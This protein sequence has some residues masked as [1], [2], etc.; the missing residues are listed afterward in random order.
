[1]QAGWNELA[2]TISGSGGLTFG[3][4]LQG[5]CDS[6]IFI[7][8]DNHL[9]LTG[10][11]TINMGIVNINSDNALG[12]NNNPIVLNG[13]IGN[14]SNTVGG[15]LEAYNGSPTLSNPVVIGPNGGTLT[16]EGGQGFQLSGPVSG[17]G[18]LAVTGQGTVILTN[19]NNNW[20]GGT[21]INGAVLQVNSGSNLG[22]GPVLITGSGVLNLQGTTNTNSTNDIN[23]YNT[24]SYGDNGYSS[25]YGYNNNELAVEAASATIGALAGTGNV[26]LTFNYDYSASWSDTPG[27]LTFGNA[28]S[29]SFYGMIE[30]YLWNNCASDNMGGN[31]IYAGTGTFTFWGQ[32]MRPTTGGNINGYSA[33]TTIESGTFTVNG[34]LAG[35]GVT[36]SGGML[37]GSGSVNTAVTVNSGGTLAGT[38]AINGNVSLVGGTLS[39]GVTYGSAV[40]AVSGASTISGGTFN[41]TLTVNSGATLSVNATIAPAAVTV[42]AGGVLQGTGTVNQAITLSGTL[43]GTLTINGNVTSAGGTLSGG[44]TYGSAVTAVSGASTISGGTF[45][46]SLTVNSGATLSVN[47]TIAPTAVTVNAGGVLQGNASITAPSFT[48]CS[49]GTLTGALGLTG[50]VVSNGGAITPGGATTMTINGSLAMQSSASALNVELGSPTAS[51]DNLSI[52]GTASLDGTLSITTLS[53]FAVGTYTLINC[54]GITGSLN[55]NFTSLPQIP[56]PSADRYASRHNYGYTYTLAPSAD[57]Q[58]LNLAVKLKGDVLGAGVLCA[59]DID[60]IYQNLTQYPSGR[61]AASWPWALQP[62]NPI[63]DVNHDGVVNQDDVTYELRTYF[64][65]SYADATLDTYT[66]YADFQIVLDHWMQHGAWADGDF[67]GDGIVDYGDFQILLDYWNPSGWNPS[68]IPEPAS[69]SLLALGGLALLRRR[70]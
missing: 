37:N 18:T 46:N 53:G 10:T 64:N 41:N 43:A 26:V 56:L 54:S 40:T 16:I 3:A 38:L 5:S 9:T 57:G 68:E 61:S 36:V 52:S 25:T 2:G 51:N 27:T 19:P 55:L 7:S 60:A 35:T 62:Y 58:Q 45:N 63:Y 50:N 32:D 8:G 34:S 70:K 24:W 13:G 59:A 44:V 22:P 66:D 21:Y 30:G 11:I 65:T 4:P 29:S 42:N 48:I 20:T 28:E 69:V 15:A 17:T 14:G 12:N 1:M 47:A 33:S 6:C 49:G 67:N 23:L 31:I 39:G